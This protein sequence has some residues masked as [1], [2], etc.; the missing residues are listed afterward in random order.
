MQRPGISRLRS[1]D[2]EIPQDRVRRGQALR[3]PNGCSDTGPRMNAATPSPLG[4]FRSLST[5]RLSNGR[6]QQAGLLAR[7]LGLCITFPDLVDP[8]V[9]DAAQTAHSCGGSPGFDPS[10]LLIPSR[11]TC[12]ERISCSNA[13]FKSIAIDFTATS[14]LQNLRVMLQV[15]GHERLNEIVPVV[16]A[17]LHAQVEFLS[18][19]RCR[20]GEFFG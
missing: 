20:G 5:P 8:V 9:F 2:D 16:I 4:K 3:H 11:G 15:I 12:R 13:H 7:G 6:L 18:R 10:S 19:R 17:W 14:F 1:P